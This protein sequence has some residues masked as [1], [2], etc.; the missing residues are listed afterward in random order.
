MRRYLEVLNWKCWFQ[1]LVTVFNFHKILRFLWKIP[2]KGIFKNTTA[3]KIDGNLGLCGGAPELHLPECPITTSDKTKHKLS[4]ILKVVISLAIMVTLAIVILILYCHSNLWVLHIQF[5]GKGRYSSV[6]QGQLFQDIN[7]VAIKVFTLET[8]GANKSF[9]VECNALRNVRHRNIVPILTACSSTDSSGNDFKALVYEFMPRG[10]LHKLLYS[11]PHDERSS[12]LCY[13]SLAQRLSIAVNVSD[14]L[15]YLHHN[16][17]GTIIHCDLKPSNIILDDNMTAHVGDFGLT[18]FITDSRTSFGQSDSTS[19]F[20]I[21]GTIGYVAPDVYS[22]R[23]VLLE[24]FIRRRPTDDIFK[25]GLS[26]AKYTEIS[27]PDKLLQIVDPQLVQELG[28]SQ[29]DP[30]TANENAAHCLL[31]VLN[32]ELCCTKS[33]LSERVSMQEKANKCTG[34]RCTTPSISRIRPASKTE[35]H[36]GASS[37]SSRWEWS[38]THQEIEGAAGVE[39]RRATGGGGGNEMWQPAARGR[40]VPRAGPV[41]QF[42]GP[43]VEKQEQAKP[44]CRARADGSGGLPFYMFLHEGADGDGKKVDPRCPNTGNPFHVCTEHCQSKKAEVSRSSETSSSSLT[45]RRRVSSSSARSASSA[46]ARGI[47]RVWSFGGRRNGDVVEEEGAAGVASPRDGG[48]GASQANV[49][50]LLTRRL[51]NSDRHLFDV[52]PQPRGGVDRLDALPDEAQQHVLSFLPLPEA[53]RAS[54]LARRWRHLWKSMPVLRITGEGR[55]LDRRGVRRLN[56]FV[57]H[58]LLLRDRSARLDACE[59]RLGTFRSQDDPQI[60]LWI[61]HALLCQARVVKVHLSIDNNSFELEDLAFVSQHLTRL[62]LCNVVL[63]NCFLNFS[64]C[65]AL[66]E[67]VMRSCHIEAG[68]IL[69]ESLKRLIAVDC[70]F[71]SYPRTR[72]SLPS[73][74]M[75]EL[76]EPWGYTPVLEN[77][78]SLLTACIKLTDCDDHCGK[79]EFGG[80]CDSYVC[81]NCGANGGS[82]GDSVLLD[83]LSEAKSL[84]LIA[85]PR[86]FIFKR[87]LMWCPTFG[88]LKTLLLNEWCVAVDLVVLIDFLQYTPVL[89][90]LTLQLCEAPINWMEREGSYNSSTENLFTS[91]QLKVVEVKFAKFDLR[92]H[93]IIMFF[94]T[95]GL[96]IE[97]MYIQRSVID[98]EEPADDFGAGPSRVQTTPISQSENAQLKS[99]IDQMLALQQELLAQQQ[100]QQQQQIISQLQR[101]QQILCDITT[102]LLKYSASSPRP[103]Q[104]DLYPA[105]VN[106]LCMS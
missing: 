6:Y 13:I 18:R 39:L 70:V 46:H 81:D 5:N 73:L 45:C 98:S 17:Q 75:L 67:L 61:R 64:S 21:N 65:P 103:P 38:G 28:F 72:I 102:Q 49:L 44:R 24:I 88:K 91:K 71:P 100:Q 99:T 55:V 22:F 101:R 74:V 79:E 16:H 4:A 63:K 32:I 104:A 23:V 19:S 9:I 95:Y 57:N 97:Q 68:S 20:A 106:S 34:R 29:E 85:I 53:V 25:D 51:R 15:A 36:R 12:D 92:V 90:K 40:C 58:L 87:D 56:R 41:E 8:R 3:I 42:S 84:E 1:W 10:D 2:T 82:N 62:E 83:G 26:I 30:V 33:S 7:L 60:N 35:R 52:M 59:I 105:V 69:S 37:G 96:N 66:K 31:S 11:T 50:S 86:V 78:P 48:F 93:Q 80:S 89:E 47:S 27:I 77:M 43:R 54:A 94:S 14:A 76:T